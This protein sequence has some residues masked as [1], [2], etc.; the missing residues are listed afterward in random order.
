MTKGTDISKGTEG[1]DVS[2]STTP[3]WY[4]LPPVGT[5]HQCGASATSLQLKIK[6]AAAAQE[7]HSL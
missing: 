7:I 3:S 4:H 5:T 2:I 1:K 6:S